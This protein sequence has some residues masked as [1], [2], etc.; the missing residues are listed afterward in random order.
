MINA[1]PR[2]MYHGRLLLRLLNSITPK[3]PR[4]LAIHRLAKA[5]WVPAGS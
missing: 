3:T 5:T 2:R 4:P 1:T